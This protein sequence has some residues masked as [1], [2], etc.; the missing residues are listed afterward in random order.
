MD[1]NYLLTTPLA[2]RLY[3]EVARD[4]P[5]IDYHNHLNVTDI[6]TDRK[7]ENITRLWISVD[8]YK[9]RAMRILGVPER[10]ITGDATDYE[11]F[12][13]WYY[14]I[15]RLV[16]NALYDWSVMEFDLIFGISLPPF[17]RDP[18]EMWGEVNERLKALS[19]RS[20]LGK[21][22]LEYS[23]PCAS[24]NDDL[25][26]FDGLSGTC[27]SLR[28]DN[29]LVP[30]E[31]LVRQLAQ[32]TGISIGDL[33]SFEQALDQR[34]MAF[35]AAGC[36]FSDHALDDGFRYLTDD[37]KND[38]RFAAI[39]RGEKLCEEDQQKLSSCILKLLGALY[40]KHSLTMQLH[41][42]AKRTTSTRLRH[43]AGPAGGYAAIGSCVDVK[44]LTNLL[45]DIEQQPYGLPKTILFTLNP[46][47]NA[48]M[49]VLSGSYSK[50]GVEAVVSQ[51][52]AWWWCDHYQGMY[53][54]LNHL[55]VYGVISTFI[56]M[57]TDSRSILSFV[58]HDYFRRI[59][60]Q[61]IGNKVQQGILPDD[62]EILSDM[63]RRIC[64]QNV[65]KCI[66]H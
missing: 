15:P 18:R 36:K 39:L 2:R 17:R 25:S 23:A 57:T 48:V 50:D 35:Q 9:H 62:F 5:I 33:Q 63:V 7:Y 32:L 4:L 10:Y 1:K 6:L 22:D 47:D 54:M 42:G 53:E 8:P 31:T 38:A 55:C 11:K 43:I 12:E 51:G 41:I 3:E 19:A 58:R 26:I 21:F 45:D 28:G 61:W 46:A 27:P 66:I 24:I 52:P 56:G 59:L 65:K 44:S 16:G 14:C 29:I 64:Y 60:C 20:I 13:K 40:A 30:D 34:L 49:S 37:G